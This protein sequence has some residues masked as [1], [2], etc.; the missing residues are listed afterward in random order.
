MS[1]RTLIRNTGRVATRLDP[2][3]VTDNLADSLDGLSDM[4]HDVAGMIRGREPLSLEILRTHGS[5]TMQAIGE[6]QRTLSGLMGD[7]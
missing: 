1:L 6:L 2:R 4:L 7:L 3:A 5:R